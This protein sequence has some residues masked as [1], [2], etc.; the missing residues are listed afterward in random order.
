MNLSRLNNVETVMV[1]LRISI[2]A[3]SGH[4]WP[5]TFIL[6]SFWFRSK[7]TK[8]VSCFMSVLDLFN[9]TLVQVDWPMPCWRILSGLYGHA[10]KISPNL[11]YPL[12]PSLRSQFQHESW[13]HHIEHRY[14]QVVLQLVNLLLG[15]SDASPGRLVTKQPLPLPR[16]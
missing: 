8:P 11:S 14:N 9:V 12:I 5:F 2:Y 4:L 10:A 7:M 3:F 13:R 1:A 16:P 15:H 6:S